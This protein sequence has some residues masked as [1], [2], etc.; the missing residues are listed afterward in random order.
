MDRPR[1]NASKRNFLAGAVGNA[2]E[3]YDFAVYGYMAPML[4]ELF[5][6]SDDPTSSLLAAF[7]A[8]AVGYV[9][10][11]AGAVV[12]G[13]I[14]DRFSRKTTLVISVIAMGVATCAIGFLPDHAEIGHAA[15]V[16]LILFRIVQGLSVGG[17]YTNSIVFLAEHAPPE[18][19]GLDASWSQF[20]T[21]VGFLLGSLVGALTATVF[22]QEAIDSWAWR[23]PFLFG[24]VIAVAGL[25]IRT[26]LTEPP[27]IQRLEHAAGS[28]VVVALRHHWRAILRLVGVIICGGV[29]FYTVFIFLASYL[30]EKRHLSTA[31]ALEINSISLVFYLALTPFAAMLSDRIGRKPMLGAVA[32]AILVLSW[33]LW[34]LMQQNAYLLILAGQMGFAAIFSVTFA[35]IP[36]VMAELLP[37]EVRCSGASIGYNLCLG[38]FGGT[39]PLIATFL[40][41]RTGNDF[42]PVYYM[43]AAAL[44]QLIA[45]VGMRDL[46]RKPLP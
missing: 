22:G 38:I 11:P 41:G 14:G 2:L 25:I 32:A 1:D 40:I 43:M 6:P 27:D 45:L 9:A 17:E 31:E 34:W 33:P 24:A 13:H 39:A 3:W 44:V 35:T 36:A 26:H 29:G 16:L 8:F 28:P 7:G 37:S 12:F 21:V 23:L 15:G 5:F 4:G 18:R 46:A 42:A 30:T 20:G 19:R 10:R